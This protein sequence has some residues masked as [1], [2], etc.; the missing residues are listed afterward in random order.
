MKNKP[1]KPTITL[2]FNIWADIFDNQPFLG[3]GISL[4]AF[5]KQ[6][7]NC[8]LCLGWAQVVSWKTVQVHGTSTLSTFF[9]IEK[10]CNG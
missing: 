9:E 6:Q 1:R 10:K 5:S 7:E 4:F 2:C 8:G 3:R